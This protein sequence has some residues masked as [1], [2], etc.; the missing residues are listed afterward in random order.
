MLSCDGQPISAQDQ[1]GA[2]DLRRLVS[3]DVLAPTELR[4]EP[5]RESVEHHQVAVAQDLVHN[6]GQQPQDAREDFRC[7]RLHTEHRRWTRH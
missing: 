1:S 4:V 6:A 7:S 3:A 2:G 5:D